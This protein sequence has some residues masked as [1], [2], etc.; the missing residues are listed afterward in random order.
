VVT[1]TN[2]GPRIVS[3]GDLADN[4]AAFLLSLEAAET[5]PNTIATYRGAVVL[6]ADYLAGSGG[7]LDIADI[8]PEHIEGWVVDMRRPVA[9][10]GRGYSQATANNRWRGA[11]RFFSWAVQRDRIDTHPM[12]KLKAPRV[13]DNPPAILTTGQLSAILGAA[14]GKRFEDVRDRAILRLFIDTGARRAEIAN[15]RWSPDDPEVNDVDVFGQGIIRV[16]GKGNKHIV[17]G[18]GKRTREALADYLNVRK[19]HPHA[20][21]PWLWLSRK[22]R[23]TESG[24]FQVVRDRGLAA[25]IPKLH[26]HD[27]RH[28]ASHYFLADGGQETDLMRQRGWSSPAM[29]RRYAA[30]TGQER[31]V[32]AAKRH[33]LGDKI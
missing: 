27:F 1:K 21:L 30:S 23:L 22:G 32:A 20:D 33:S 19:R 6:L 11:Q 8:R 3:A 14:K 18:L 29:L 7:P 9:E 16:V 17:M 4:L 12:A 5:S 15:L 10:G 25:G 28:A 26:P 31:S 24:V 13:D 2:A